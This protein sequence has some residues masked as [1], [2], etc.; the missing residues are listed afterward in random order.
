M[1]IVIPSNIS[2]GVFVQSAVDNNDLN[3]EMLDGKQTTH[4]TAIVAY[5][6]EQ[7]GPNSPQNVLADHS[8]RRRSLE[9]PPPSQTIYECSVH[10]RRPNVKAFLG[11]VKE[12]DFRSPDDLQASVE[13]KDLI[14]FLLRLHQRVLLSSELN[15]DQQITPS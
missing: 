5:Q 13:T 2:P 6:R 7:F 11:K 9:L 10:G 3:E 12:E 15:Q 4:A 14:W 8:A 1:G